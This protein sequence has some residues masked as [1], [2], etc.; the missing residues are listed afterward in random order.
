M[1]DPPKKGVKEAVAQC[2]SAG[3]KVYMITGDHPITAESIARQ[4][5]II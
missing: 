5:G 3:V 4:V 1:M 2:R